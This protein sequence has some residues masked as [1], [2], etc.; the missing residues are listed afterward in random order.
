[1]DSRY[2]YQ[3][4][5]GKAC[6]QHDMVLEDLKDL[7]RST[8]SRKVLCKKAFD[9]VKNQKYDGHQR[10]L[11]SLVHEFFD[12]KPTT[13]ENRTASYT[14]TEINSENQELAEE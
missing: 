14:E 4:D 10:T 2:I 11:A 6:F 13:H 8:D 1:M 5:P 7:P 9:T 3:N 12:K